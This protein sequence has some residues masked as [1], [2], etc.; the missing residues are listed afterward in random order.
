MKALLYTQLKGNN[1]IWSSQSSHQALLSLL[2]AE[3]WMA[4]PERPL[5]LTVSN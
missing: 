1:N 2:A 3:T 5:P 4:R